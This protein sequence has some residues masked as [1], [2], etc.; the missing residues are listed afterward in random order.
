MPKETE[1]G[2]RVTGTNMRSETECAREGITQLPLIPLKQKL[3]SLIKA[4]MLTE[5]RAAG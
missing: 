4:V 1:K 3:N 2:K 5:I